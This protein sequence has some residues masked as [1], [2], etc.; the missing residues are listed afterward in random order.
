MDMSFPIRL[1][2]SVVRGFGRGSR[3]LG[4][5][6]ANLSREEI[7]ENLFSSLSPGIYYGIASIEGR[8]SIYKAGEF[9]SLRNIQGRERLSKD[10]YGIVL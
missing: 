1:R 6:T 2:S 4:I 3:E 9:I 8:E 5:P 10:N 7:G